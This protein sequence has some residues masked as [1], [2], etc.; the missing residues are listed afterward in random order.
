MKLI[1]LENRI[2]FDGAVAIDATSL[3]DIDDTAELAAINVSSDTL[4]AQVAVVDASI[5]GY[6][7]ILDG[8]PV[9]MEVILLSGSASGISTILAEL[10]GRSDIRAIHVFGHGAVGE[11]QLGSDIISNDTLS[12][13]AEHLST[14]G[15][16]LTENGDIL[17]YNCSVASTADGEILIDR[18]ASLALADVAASDDLTGRSGDWD[19]EY[20]AGKVE[21]GALS[22]DYSGDL[23]LP[24][25]R[26]DTVNSEVFLGGDY[27]EIGI[28]SSGS[29]GT[30]GTTPAGFYG[31]TSSRLG[32]SNDADGYGVGDDLR[33]D[34]FLP[35]TP[36]E[37]FAV[38]YKISGTA[39]SYENY[40]LLNDVEINGVTVTDT[41]DTAAGQLSATVVGTAGGNLKFEK[42]ISFLTDST[43]FK[44]EVV[45]TNVGTST[46]EEVRYLRGFDPDNT[47]FFGGEYVTVNSIPNTIAND[48]IAVVSA[49]SKPGDAYNTASGSQAT[50]LF[51]SSDSRAKTSIGDESF[52]ITNAYDSMIYDDAAVD[53]TTSSTGDEGIS[54]GIEEAS[55]AVGDSTTFTFYTSLD[56]KGVQETIDAIEAAASSGI[57]ED[58]SYTFK[59]SDFQSSGNDVLRIRFDTLPAHGTLSYNGT[60]ITSVGELDDSS[61]SGSF[62]ATKL[63]YTPDIDFNGDDPFDWVGATTVDG[64]LTDSPATFTVTVNAVND[65]PTGTGV[66]G[67]NFVFTEDASGNVDLS[68]LVLSDVD[69]STSDIDLKLSVDAGTLSASAAGGVTVSGDGTGSL[70]LTGTISEINTYLDTVSRIEY[71]GATNANGAS[72]ATLSIAVNDKGNTGAG[73]GSDVSLGTV[74]IDITAVNDDPAVTGLPSDVTVTEDAASNLDLSAVTLSDV[75]SASGTIDLVITAGAGTLA[76]TSGGSVTVSGSGSG[77]LTLSGTV[78]NIDTY[79][80]TASNIQY[81]GASNANGNNA[82]TITLTAD[83]NGNTGSGG[84]GTV[85]LGSV[86]VDITAVNDAPTSIGGISDLSAKEVGLA[87][88]DTTLNSGADATGSAGDLLANAS[89]VDGDTLTVTLARESTVGSNQVVAAASTST[90]NALNVSGLYGSLAVGA[91]GS[92]VYS[93]DNSNSTVNALNPLETIND[94]FV[95]TVSDGNGGTV[96]Q[97]ITFTIEGTNDAPRSSG[98]ISGSTANEVGE[99][100]GGAVL[101]AGSGATGNAAALMANVSDAEGDNLVVSSAAPHGGSFVAV[102]KGTTSSTGGV[103]ITGD[104]G[105]LVIGSDGSYEYTVD[106]TNTAVNALDETQ[107]L[108]DT[109]SITVSDNLQTTA[110]SF[111]FNSGTAPTG[112]VTSGGA[113]FI[114]GSNIEYGY[115]GGP[116]A[117]NNTTNVY[118]ASTSTGLP[119]VTTS[120]V[121]VSNGGT[122]SFYIAMGDDSSSPIQAEHLDNGEGIDLSYS[123]DNG[124]NWIDVAYL[125]RLGNSESADQYIAE[126]TWTYVEY[127]IPVAAQTASTEFRFQQRS[128]SGSSYDNWGIDDITISSAILGAGSVEQQL[129]I[130]IDGTN[131]GPTTSATNVSGG[132]TEGSILNDTGSISFSDVDLTDR[133]TATEATKSVSALKADGITS[134]TLTAAQQQAIEDAFTIGA[135]SGNTNTGSINWDY[136]ITEAE[137]DFLAKD[138]VVTAVFTITV[139]DGNGVTSSQDVTVTITGSNDGPIFGAPYEPEMQIPLG[140]SFEYDAS[141]SFSD[142][143]GTDAFTFTATNLP[144]G[145][146][147]DSSTGVISGTP[148]VSGPFSIV[149]R[150]TDPYGASVESNSFTVLVLAPPQPAPPPQAEMHSGDVNLG[151]K[152]IP[153]VTAA[154]SQSSLGENAI[155]GSSLVQAPTIQGYVAASSRAVIPDA[156]VLGSVQTAPNERILNVDVSAALSIVV[157]DATAEGQIYVR[158]A[159]GQELPNWLVFD[160][161]NKSFMGIVPDG[162][163]GT[164][165]TVIVVRRLDGVDEVIPVSLDL[166]NLSGVTQSSCDDTASNCGVEGDGAF[167]KWDDLERDLL[168][169]S[170]P[171]QYAKLTFGFHQKLANI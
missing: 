104:Y 146:I 70:T 120:A 171:I 90:S 126:G 105:T 11:M 129:T 132:I 49:T 145:L 46:L 61:T 12:D 113:A 95:V 100:E 22:L 153:Q 14:L 140:V 98:A 103:T 73:G 26:S 76:A 13:Y 118:W 157:V 72:A 154:A 134:L 30:S 62:D 41:S 111:D 144:S 65:D 93:V 135:A 88:D 166:D 150:G 116:E 20:V 8:I 141:K 32:L 7:Q 66:P 9:D 109:F 136:T 87:A 43:F 27:I 130:T 115:V 74:G 156:S 6:Q 158:L 31:S 4:G 3:I 85:N 89:D 149:I 23:A 50:V 131:D 67:S 40:G 71:L 122:F 77:T 139:N 53:G 75:D 64:S 45:L 59:V 19:L 48:G 162:V 138:E 25:A 133:P 57:D 164:L 47:K 160:R 110:T 112:W 81:T 1:S 94:V 69:A 143:D 38:G 35:G 99:D 18:I 10:G 124:T 123:T 127:E 151:D 55:L 155:G 107:S 39:S 96:D 5:D 142:I 163:T 102:S 36:A 128:S 84:G 21:V 148:I 54:I 24:G 168:E 121:D 161:E 68:S 86:N 101:Q 80:N 125:Q 91:D 44:T 137:L 2:V 63:I 78:S 147:I 33:I 56:N 97:S 167:L 108:D 34:Y 15:D 117:G 152:F 83:D 114:T 16:V 159:D 29:Y 37:G 60:N 106:N 165:D 169:R 92:Y 58:T 52:R 82:T 170:A 42:T 51:F 79:L 28:H 17:F 119:G